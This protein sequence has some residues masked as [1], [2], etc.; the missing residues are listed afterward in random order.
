MTDAMPQM[1]PNIVRK[2]RILWAR[3]VARVCFKMS[4]RFILGSRRNNSGSVQ[5]VSGL[6]DLHTGKQ[7]RRFRGTGCYEDQSAL[8]ERAA[9]LASSLASRFCS[10][11]MWAMENSRERA[12]LRQV[13]LSE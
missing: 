12:S 1:I 11:L 3:R 2:L 7:V 6:H 10:R 8:P 9:W 4:C 13:Q 5:I